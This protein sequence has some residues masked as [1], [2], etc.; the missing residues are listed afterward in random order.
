M[1]F[2]LDGRQFELD[3]DQVRA[4]VAGRAP[5]GVHQHWVEIDGLEWP[6]KQVLELA[7]GVHRS[8]FTSHTALRQLRRLGFRTSATPAGSSRAQPAS[9]WVPTAPVLAQPPADVAEPTDAFKT[10]FEFAAT[11]DLTARV[12][13]L[14][15]AL[16]GADRTA[17]ASTAASCGLNNDIL[18]AALLIRKHLGRISDI[19]HATVITQ[20]LPLILEE[21]ERIAVRPS[22]AAGNDP[23]RRFDLETDRRVAEFKVSVWKGPDAMRKR[24]TFTDLVQLALDESGRRAQLFVTGRRAIDFLQTST[25]TADWALN[26]ASPILRDRFRA[27]FGGLAVKIC[28]FTQGQA[29]RVELIDL[30]GLVP[31]LEAG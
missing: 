22:L 3:R 27:R 7:L 19:I 25:S 18:H 16:H 12:A 6:P 26:R 2:T 29:S 11:G 13:Q 5:E 24:G 4:K 23:G 17:A 20:A 1:I 31:A 14:E 10:L 15:A 30:A 28:D 21:G 8:E 9:M